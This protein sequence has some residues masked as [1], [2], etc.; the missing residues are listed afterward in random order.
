[1][2][3]RY[4]QRVPIDCSVMFAGDNCVGEGRILDLSLPGCLLESQK[5][6]TAGE[7]LQLSLFLPDRQ[8]PLH[9]AL[10]AV[11]W[12]EGSKLG[13]EFIRTSEDEQRRLEQ[14]VRRSTLSQPQRFID[15]EQR[16]SPSWTDKTMNAFRSSM[17]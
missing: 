4:S 11:R 13:T 16:H 8:A 17:S 15:L 10:A 9:I 2:Q 12:A 3:N 6:M 14:I 5:K 1:M 7:Y